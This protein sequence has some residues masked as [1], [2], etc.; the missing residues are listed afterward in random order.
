MAILEGLLYVVG[1]SDGIAA[2]NQV[3][4]SSLDLFSETLIKLRRVN[5]DLP[6]D[7]FS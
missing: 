6:F 5:N 7:L 4:F 3:C 1:G 2:L